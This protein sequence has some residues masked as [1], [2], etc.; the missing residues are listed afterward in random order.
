MWNPI[1]TGSVKKNATLTGLRT[2]TAYEIKVAAA[3]NLTGN[4]SE[5]VN[6]TTLESGKMPT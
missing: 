1:Y 2:F 4:Y 5:T 3:T 6:V